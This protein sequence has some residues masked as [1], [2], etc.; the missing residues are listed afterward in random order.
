MSRRNSLN[1]S[2][3]RGCLVLIQIEQEKIRDRQ[4]IETIRNMGVLTD[5]VQRIAKNQMRPDI[6]VVQRF[7][8]CMIAGQEKLPS[9]RIPDA[10]SEIAE[11]MLHTVLLP[12]NVSVE[13]QLD[14]S[15][16]GRDLAALS[17]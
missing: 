13:N 11:Q 6:R 17:F 7:Y 15:S 2:E 5:T 14:V 12:Y 4:I 16:I 3:S 1:V 8:P 10:K 9:W